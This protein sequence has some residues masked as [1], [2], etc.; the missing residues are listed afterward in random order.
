M[1]NFN[2]KTV[3]H[4]HA[5]RLW[6]TATIIVYTESVANIFS[7]TPFKLFS[8]LVAVIFNSNFFLDVFFFY[9]KTLDNKS[10]LV[11]SREEIFFYYF[12]IHRK[13][14]SSDSNRLDVGWKA[15]LTYSTSNIT[16]IVL[17]KRERNCFTCRIF[18]THCS[19]VTRM[20]LSVFSVFWWSSTLFLKC[21]AAHLNFIRQFSSSFF[22][23]YPCA[24]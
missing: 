24:L 13:T 8:F 22:P 4:E 1:L 9:F 6:G 17:S 12:C 10:S 5:V 14:L 15:R 2:P 11:Y 16:L 23:S 19:C 18:I 3:V 20:F 21:F 7:P